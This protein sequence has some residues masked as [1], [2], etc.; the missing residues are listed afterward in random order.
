MRG[1]AGGRPGLRRPR[2]TAPTRS[3][4]RLKISHLDSIFLSRVA[5]AN[6]GGL[7]GE[8]VLCL[9]PAAGAGLGSARSLSGPL[10]VR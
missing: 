10:G 5:W 2:L 7:P 8:W 1:A 6:V 3:V 4:S 9:D